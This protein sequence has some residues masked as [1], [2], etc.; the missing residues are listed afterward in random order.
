[1]L[2]SCVYVSRLR[3]AGRGPVD[4]LMRPLFFSVPVERIVVIQIMSTNK[5][6]GRGSRRHLSETAMKRAVIAGFDSEMAFFQE[7][8]WDGVTDTKVA[9]CKSSLNNLLDACDINH[10]KTDR[11]TD[12]L[13]SAFMASN[14]EK[15][16]VINS[17]S[18]VDDF[19]YINS[20]RNAITNSN[21]SLRL[22]KNAVMKILEEMNDDRREYL[23]N[24]GITPETATADTFKPIK[25]VYVAPSDKER[26]WLL[27][28]ST[29]AITGKSSMS[30]DERSARLDEYAKTSGYYDV[31]MNRIVSNEELRRD[32]DAIK[33]DTDYEDWT[34]DDYVSE[35][36]DAG[37]LSEVNWHDED[38]V[39]AAE[40]GD[41]AVEVQ[42][43]TVRMYEGDGYYHV[44]ELSDV[45]ETYDDDSTTLAR[46]V[47]IGWLRNN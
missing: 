22:R 13:V 11:Y 3:Q 29:H 43:N 6:R 35:S 27:T 45:I 34:F 16:N 31:E 20:C 8:H 5:H 12:L 21:V 32:W 47:A 25:H 14:L 46:E 19:V 10:G 26:Q 2:R 42:G 40:A 1:M 17:D 41:R 9:E 36:I 39:V 24:M 28:G 23:H 18:V 33:D 4:V 38:D 15:N 44:Y 7:N 30:Y 37:N